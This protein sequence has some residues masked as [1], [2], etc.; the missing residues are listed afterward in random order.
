MMPR[1]P[2]TAFEAAGNADLDAEQKK[3]LA[4]LLYLTLETLEDIAPRC[5]EDE[6]A[7]LMVRVGRAEFCLQDMI[8]DLL[9]H[10]FNAPLPGVFPSVGDA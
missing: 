5:C 9:E 8:A 2:L 4:L 10:T 7:D 1:H 6:P 3:T